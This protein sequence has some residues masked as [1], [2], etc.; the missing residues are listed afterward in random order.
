[1][2]VDAELEALQTLAPQVWDSD[3][4]GINGSSPLVASLSIV[5]KL[6]EG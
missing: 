1:V 3:V 5:V 2:E 6:L 4:D